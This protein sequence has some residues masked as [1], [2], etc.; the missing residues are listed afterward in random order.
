MQAHIQLLNG[1]VELWTCASCDTATEVMKS[2]FS[3][4]LRSL[5]YP[6]LRCPDSM[7]HSSV[8]CTVPHCAFHGDY[9]DLLMMVLEKAPRADVQQRLESLL[10]LCLEAPRAS[11]GV[12]CGIPVWCHLLP[13]KF[14]TAVLSEDCCLLS[15]KLGD[16]ALNDIT[17]LMQHCVRSVQSNPRAEYRKDL[18]TAH[19]VINVLFSSGLI[20]TYNCLFRVSMSVLRGIVAAV[21]ERRATDADICACITVMHDLFT[22]P[23]VLHP[24]SALAVSL[25]AML[26]K[27]P[28]AIG[29][30]AR[31][32]QAK[33]AKLLKY[34]HVDMSGEL[35][36]KWLRGLIASPLLLDEE[37]RA[38]GF[39]AEQALLSRLTCFL[40]LSKATTKRNIVTAM[41]DGCNLLQFAIAH[42]CH[43][44]G[45]LLLDS[46]VYFVTEEDP[47]TLQPLVYRQCFETIRDKRGVFNTNTYIA[48]MQSLY[49]RMR[50]VFE[51]AST[52]SV[53]ET[54]AA[55]HTIVASGFPSECVTLCVCTGKGGFETD[56]KKWRT[57]LKECLSAF[58]VQLDDMYAV[59]FDEKP[60]KKFETWY[61]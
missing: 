52:T 4:E 34:K 59:V 11:F 9:P 23:S 51:K 31:L 15:M 28:K 33:A 38:H 50:R 37:E 2:L 18:K 47:G 40:R 20:H 13:Q 45:R 10:T 32:D 57:L 55:L 54:M 35:G 60:I 12:G 19:S 14:V 27:Y 21:E 61:S 22:M 25:S 8:G 39:T 36:S 1:L 43:V 16:L 6:L 5:R 53:T 30:L 44:L 56:M 7:V 41:V 17:V 26:V 46:I 48:S 42:W 3:K 49:A 29:L 24:K 58:P